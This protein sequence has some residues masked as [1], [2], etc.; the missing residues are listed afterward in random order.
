MRKAVVVCTGRGIGLMYM[1]SRFPFDRVSLI[2]VFRRC[3]ESM[4][5]KY[6]DACGIKLR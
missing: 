3:V 4:D 1:A 6:N 5:A 2:L